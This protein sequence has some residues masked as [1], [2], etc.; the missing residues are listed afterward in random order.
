MDTDNN[1]V[2]ARGGEMGAGW[3]RAKREKMG[4]ACN[5]VN[6]KEKRNK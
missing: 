2:K 6:N 4:N 3:R 1:V 5:S